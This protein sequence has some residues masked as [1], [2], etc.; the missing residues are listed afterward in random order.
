[1]ISTEIWAAI[2]LHLGQVVCLRKGRLEE[3]MQWSADPAEAAD[4][5]QCEGIYGIHVIDLDAA[6]GYDSNR[7]AVKSIVRK[8]KIPVQVG[9][10]IQSYD[11]ARRLLSSGVDRVVLGTLAYE[12]PP[13][14]RRIIKAFGT[15]RIVVATDYRNG[16]IVTHGWTK[17]RGLGV[18]EAVKILDAAGIE[19]VLATATEFDGIAKGP[20]L[21]T[22]RSIRSST[23][24]HILASGGIRTIKDVHELQQMGIESI[25]VGR[26]L[27]EGTLD[28][29]EL[30]RGA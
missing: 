7:G 1:M 29:S 16:K 9:G 26:A 18:I 11:D 28:P 30:N 21:D 23:T 17:E 12:N 24:M 25:V 15:E 6:F 22:L 14:L 2:D 3:P 4:R 5:W 19:T 8:A 13:E 20:D 10:G 27:H